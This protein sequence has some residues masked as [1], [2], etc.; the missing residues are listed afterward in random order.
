MDELRLQVHFNSY[1]MKYE[2]LPTSW[3][4]PNEH[5]EFLPTLHA[6]QYDL[7]Q[8]NQSF[9]PCRR[10]ATKSIPGPSQE[11]VQAWGFLHGSS[12]CSVFLCRLLQSWPIRIRETVCFCSSSIVCDFNA[13]LLILCSS[14]PPVQ[15]LPSPQLLITGKISHQT[16]MAMTRAET[17]GSGYFAQGTESLLCKYQRRRKISS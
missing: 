14:C 12:S 8:Y 2:C 11:T 4:V 6:N 1:K 9:P 10:W 13:N 3:P 5:D 16:G 17:S 15:L 7:L